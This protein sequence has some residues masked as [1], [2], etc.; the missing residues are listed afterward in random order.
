[1]AG[2]KQIK[3]VNPRRF[4][5]PRMFYFVLEH[6]DMYTGPAGMGEEAYHAEVAL[7]RLNPVTGKLDDNPRILR[8][9]NEAENP[10]FRISRPTNLGAV[11]ADPDTVP[12]KFSK[13]LE[14]WPV[15]KDSKKLKPIGAAGLPVVVVISEPLEPMS[16]YVALARLH[17]GI[18]FGPWTKIGQTRLAFTELDGE[19][20]IRDLPQCDPKPQINAKLVRAGG[21]AAPAAAATQ[22]DGEPTP[23]FVIPRDDYNKPFKVEVTAR[24]NVEQYG[25]GALAE[26]YAEHIPLTKVYVNG[27]ESKH[28]SHTI[29]KIANAVTRIEVVAENALGNRSHAVNILL[30]SYQKEGD[31]KGKVLQYEAEKQSFVQ[32]AAA[33]P[34][35]RFRVLYEGIPYLAPHK[36]DDLTVA[37][38][39]GSDAMGKKVTLRR[40]EKEHGWSIY[41]GPDLWPD[42]P[43][44]VDW[45]TRQ[46]KCKAV[47]NIVPREV[48]LDEWAA[49]GGLPADKQ[50]YAYT[51]YALGRTLP[52]DPAISQGP[53]PIPSF[54]QALI[55]VDDCRWLSSAMIL[56]P[57]SGRGLVPGES[58]LQ[59][60][61]GEIVQA[62]MLADSSVT[63]GTFEFPEEDGKV[64]YKGSLTVEADFANV[65]GLPAVAAG[66]RLVSA[67]GNVPLTAVKNGDVI[68]AQAFT[69]H[70]LFGYRLQPDEHDHGQKDTTDYQAG[71]EWKYPPYDIAGAPLDDA[72]EVVATAVSQD[73]DELNF[74]AYHHRAR[75]WNMD[76]TGTPDNTPRDEPNIPTANDS[77]LSPVWS[78]TPTADNLYT[79]GP[80][81]TVCSW[82]LSG[83]FRLVTQEYLSADMVAA[84]AETRH[85][86]LAF[87]YLCATVV[88]RDDNGTELGELVASWTRTLEITKRRYIEG[89]PSP[90]PALVGSSPRVGG[91]GTHRVQGLNRKL[92]DGCVYVHNGELFQA[93]EDL[94]LIGKVMDLTV[95]RTYLSHSLFT[96]EV[97]RNWDWIGNMRLVELPNGEVHLM[98]GECQVE[99]YRPGFKEIAQ[100]PEEMSL[101]GGTLRFGSPVRSEVI[102]ARNIA[103]GQYDYSSLYYQSQYDSPPG[104]YKSL[105]KANPVNLP[106]PPISHVGTTTARFYLLGKH[107]TIWTFVEDARF[108]SPVTSPSAT[109]PGATTDEPVP[110]V[111]SHY[112]LAAIHHRCQSSMNTLVRDAKECL[113]GLVDDTG[114]VLRLRFRGTGQDRFLRQI[115]DFASRRVDY[116]Q[117]ARNLSKCDAVSCRQTKDGP[118]TRDAVEYE[119]GLQS[120]GPMPNALSAVTDGKGDILRVSHCDSSRRITDWKTAAGWFA[121][122]AQWKKDT[123]ATTKMTLTASYLVPAENGGL[124]HL[125][126]EKVE[127]YHIRHLCSSNAAE[128]FKHVVTVAA[129]A[130]TKSFIG[131]AVTEYDYGAGGEVSSVRLP[132]GKT[133][134]WDYLESGPGA[135]NLLCERESG[136]NTP[137]TRITA[138]DARFNLPKTVKRAINSATQEARWGVTS[139]NYDPQ[140]NPLAV[141]GPDGL[142]EERMWHDGLI[143]WHKG[144]LGAVTIFR[145]FGGNEN[146]V[147]GD[148]HLRNGFLAQTILLDGP[149]DEPRLQ[150]PAWLRAAYVAWPSA[151]ASW[152][153]WEREYVED[154]FPEHW[155]PLRVFNDPARALAMESLPY[156]SGGQRTTFV[157]TILGFN[158]HIVDPDR[159]ALGWEFNELGLPLADPDAREYAYDH[160][161]LQDAM[162]PLPDSTRLI[163]HFETDELG[164]VLQ[165]T[166]GSLVSYWE[167]DPDGRVLCEG[168]PGDYVTVN[169]YDER[170]LVIKRIADASGVKSTTTY[171]YNEDGL[172]IFSREPNGFC[173]AWTYNAGNQVETEVTGAGAF[174]RHQ[175]GTGG[176]LHRREATQ[177]WLYGYGLEQR[178]AEG[179]R[180]PWELPAIYTPEDS[181]DVASKL[182]IPDRAKS[183][184]SLP[185]AGRF[186][187]SEE[188]VYDHAGRV[189]T[190]KGVAG[191]VRAEARV[192][193]DGRAHL[194]WR[195]GGPTIISRLDSHGRAVEE[196]ICYMDFTDALQWEDTEATP[197]II[198][199]HQ[200]GAL[201]FSR[202][203][204]PDAR[205]QTQAIVRAG[206]QESA[207]T[208]DHLLRQVT[209]TETSLAGTTFFSADAHS[210]TYVDEFTPWGAAKTQRRLTW[211]V[212]LSENNGIAI[213][214]AYEFTA[215]GR[216][217]RQTSTADKRWIETEFSDFN[218]WGP[219]RIYVRGRYQKAREVKRIREYFPG[220]QEKAW[221]DANGCQWNAT[222]D[223][224]GNHV[225]LSATHGGERMHSRVI[226]RDAIGRPI[227]TLDRQLR[228]FAAKQAT[229][230]ELRDEDFIRVVSVAS[231]PRRDVDVEREYSLDGDLRWEEQCIQLA[232]NRL[233]RFN[234]RNSRVASLMLPQGERN[235]W[236]WQ[237]TGPVD[238]S[239]VEICYV[240]QDRDTRPSGVRLDGGIPAYPPLVVA[241]STLSNDGTPQTP[242]IGDQPGGLIESL[243]YGPDGRP[244]RVVAR[245]WN[246]ATGRKNLCGAWLRL[247]ETSKGAV[248]MFAALGDSVMPLK[249]DTESFREQDMVIYLRT[250]YQTYGRTND[251]A[252][253]FL[254]SET[255][256]VRK[257]RN[258]NWTHADSV[259]Y[260][261]TQQ[262]VRAQVNRN[263]INGRDKTQD[264]EPFYG[265]TAHQNALSQTEHGVLD[266]AGKFGEAADRTLMRHQTWRAR[267]G[268]LND[269]AVRSLVR[270]WAAALKE[271]IKKD[272]W[273]G[274]WHDKQRWVDVRSKA[275]GFGDESLGE[276]IED[277]QN[278]YKREPDEIRR[279]VS[280]P[281]GGYRLRNYPSGESY[282]TPGGIVHRNVFGE[283]VRFVE[284]EPADAERVGSYRM[285]DKGGAPQERSDC[286]LLYDAFGRLVI[287]DAPEIAVIRDRTGNVEVFAEYL[288]PDGVP[289]VSVNPRGARPHVG[290]ADSGG[291][292]ELTE[293]M[294]EKESGDHDRKKRALIRLNADVSEADL[295]GEMPEKGTNPDGSVRIPRRIRLFKR[296]NELV[297]ELTVEGVVHPRFAD[298][299]GP[300][301]ERGMPTITAEKA[302]AIDQSV[303]RM[304]FRNVRFASR[305]YLNSSAN[306]VLFDGCIFEEGVTIYDAGSWG[307][308]EKRDRNV[309]F[310]NCHFHERVVI[311]NPCGG[312]I[313]FEHNLFKPKTPPIGGGT[314]INYSEGGVIKIVYTQD[315]ADWLKD[316]GADVEHYQFATYV[317]AYNNLWLEQGAG[318][319]RIVSDKEPLI[320]VKSDYDAT[321]TKFNVVKMLFTEAFNIRGQ[322]LG[323]D[324]PS[325]RM[326]YQMLRQQWWRTASADLPEQFAVIPR[327]L[328][329]I[330][331]RMR[332]PKQPTPGPMETVVAHER[333]RITYRYL[334]DGEA[335]VQRE[336]TDSS[337]GRKDVTRI[338]RATDVGPTVFVDSDGTVDVELTDCFGAPWCLY[339][340]REGIH[341]PFDG[342]KGSQLQVGDKLDDKWKSVW[343]EESKCRNSGILKPQEFPRW[344]FLDYP[345]FW[346]QILEWDLLKGRR[347]VAGW[348][349]STLTPGLYLLG[350]YRLMEHEQN[351]YMTGWWTYVPIISIPADVWNAGVAWET[352]ERGM[353]IFHGAMAATGILDVT[354]IGGLVKSGIK[355]GVKA[356]V[357]RAAVKLG[358]KETLTEGGERVIKGLAREGL[359]EGLE[360][361]GRKGLENAARRGG[362]SASRKA[363]RWTRDLPAGVGETDWAG[364]MIVSKLGTRSDRLLVLLHESTHSFLT[365]PG[366]F[367]QSIRRALYQKTMTFRY[368]E[369]ALAESVAQ[370]GARSVTK[371]SLHNAI[372]VGL[373]F[374]IREGY[375][376][377]RGLMK[378][379]AIGAGAVAVTGSTIGL[380]GWATDG[381]D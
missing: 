376:T 2:E 161:H 30:P 215:D 86:I 297:A 112:V 168:E 252:V 92:R 75:L 195:A 225:G 28:L 176:D 42:G 148:G 270:A 342:A 13:T 334:Y 154:E 38:V 99:V 361:F 233:V 230:E 284:P 194:E 8:S 165:E 39:S 185:P 339:R 94:H 120:D 262:S 93:A 95:R 351:L 22:P 218:Y 87:G 130:E 370:V 303:G 231:D 36:K 61:L 305:L 234:Y 330:D 73:D 1:M 139:T 206:N 227:W 276:C 319:D 315:W 306:G 240:E 131:E 182:A 145:Y 302:R 40:Q 183:A 224:N 177:S 245:N 128:V 124:A 110:G 316:H 160:D 64:K 12:L 197:G 174:I 202:T 331:G 232:G 32:E 91:P 235:N 52:D 60:D 117:A 71:S 345:P 16:D 353:A 364:N 59:A 343:A 43:A 97:G 359:E 378:E 300:Y 371:S 111:R 199:T 301:E 140:G 114:R 369:E 327:I 277:Q 243:S 123:G 141:T 56:A 308:S 118:A 69:H 159:N 324:G 106:G 63:A 119:Y 335:V 34:I 88:L 96:S 127:T 187:Q 49:D 314:G 326:A 144:F 271:D 78:G 298:P 172:P 17:D 282:E 239:S 250:Q 295:G 360:R 41:T 317:G 365:P 70:G 265:L 307:P 286:S 167:Y 169:V 132:S 251:G 164:N 292:T 348:T 44:R 362:G 213:R 138:Y 48:S 121:Y 289:L 191:T 113:G 269:D 136:S 246:A 77:T 299:D 257:G 103:D 381:R 50:L 349:G 332:D 236:I 149:G 25:K 207:Y 37:V 223:G 275:E 151:T 74:L 105:I 15:D 256:Q 137:V 253:D 313:L 147:P 293:R 205:V 180:D 62:R 241:A 322:V 217:R 7:Y 373:A 285:V 90:Q 135:G 294:Y 150:D 212:G 190:V 374:P 296:W 26:T 200:H 323:Q 53:L 51:N 19:T 196:R 100:T 156:Y 143:R 134:Y 247:P 255:H 209:A 338:I 179:R 377:A 189:S 219:R 309:H 76:D 9:W 357:R 356:G 266:K 329:D 101:S 157:P 126:K 216:V 254:Q 203:V 102:P 85:Q 175:Y 341:Q 109:A 290:G 162:T 375:V 279:S 352:G 291:F 146:C 58:V 129:Q 260:E 46:K 287:K 273:E 186:L 221:T 281:G 153:D 321:K 358:L 29:D 350:P 280:G 33:Q 98:N 336:M 220:G 283:P 325:Y 258:I 170:G 211:G 173:L 3:K 198:T 208:Y 115:E 27:Q 82:L 116:A 380:I 104:A 320:R 31:E 6:S 108:H 328:W 363:L 264:D 304:R 122:S 57:R 267:N 81:V 24:G 210:A 11:K 163:V 366:R 47:I 188:F 310:V 222:L 248:S 229:L 367:L 65:Y 272:E 268:F 201:G 278:A 346:Q 18:Q 21:G 79:D 204:Y 344:P 80:P 133:M 158:E 14:G 312:V 72:Q 379:V 45:P 67:E 54:T 311:E 274:E 372:R 288:P 368:L 4:L 89:R 20:V 5:L 193:V 242:Q 337:G 178:K 355:A 340:A 107:G 226:M 166:R 35:R 10:A 84:R 171:A 347:G 238:G 259:I 192:S 125:D 237:K 55:E 181:A 261:K 142:V 83:V 354:G 155:A 318:P 66:I 244:T 68:A 249:P 263:W 333:G 152:S 214:D 184:P 228:Y 23:E